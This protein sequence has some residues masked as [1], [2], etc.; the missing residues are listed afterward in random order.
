[1][2]SAQRP[3]GDEF[4]GERSNM[5]TNPVKEKLQ[6]GE[7]TFGT[8]LSLGNLYA[9]RVLARMGWDWLTLDLEH[10]PIDMDQAAAIFGA[11]AAG[12]AASGFANVAEAQAAICGVRRKVYT[13]NRQNHEMYQGLYKLYRELHDAFGTTQ[14]SGK[15]NH[16][17]KELIT[18][19]EQQ[20]R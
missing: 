19:R 1:M 2:I 6:R 15:L 9:A 8:W 11:V 12:R 20:R 13:P 4:R 14:W 3:T 16:V 10:S 5:K 18:I 7:P 17:M